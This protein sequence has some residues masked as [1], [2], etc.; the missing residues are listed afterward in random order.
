[1]SEVE[2]ELGNVVRE[3]AEQSAR[4]SWSSD[5]H[6][7]VDGSRLGMAWLRPEEIR[8]GRLEMIRPSWGAIP[9]LGVVVMFSGLT[10]TSIRASGIMDDGLVPSIQNS[11]DDVLDAIGLHVDWSVP[12]GPVAT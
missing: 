2:R 12:N 6:L 11:L 10:S 5:T 9:F 1:M 7:V 8:A 3:K 4:N